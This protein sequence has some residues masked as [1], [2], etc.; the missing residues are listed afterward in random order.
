[1]TPKG[2]VTHGLRTA[3]PIEDMAGTVIHLLKPWLVLSLPL[4]GDLRK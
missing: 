3:A 4:F 1:M 2:V